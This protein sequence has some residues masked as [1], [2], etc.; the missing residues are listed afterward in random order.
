MS[1]VLQLMMYELAIVAQKGQSFLVLD[2][3][4]VLW[5]ITI[6]M[7]VKRNSIAD[8]THVVNRRER[9]CAPLSIM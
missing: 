2:L 1:N 7:E 4:I 8:P 5:W 6:Q 9:K 3:T